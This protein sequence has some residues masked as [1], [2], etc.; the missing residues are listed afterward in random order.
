MTELMRQAELELKQLEILEAESPQWMQSY[1]R[2]RRHWLECQ[3]FSAQ[4]AEKCLADTFFPQSNG[5]DAYT[6]SMEAR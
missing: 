5:F 1:I 3:L 2:S 4:I 6:V